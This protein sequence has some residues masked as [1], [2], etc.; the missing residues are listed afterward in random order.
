MLPV[1][2]V[3]RAAPDTIVEAAHARIIR[4]VCAWLSQASSDARHAPERIASCISIGILGQEMDRVA[5]RTLR[6]AAF[7]QYQMCK[8]IYIGCLMTARAVA[9]P[10]WHS[11]WC[12]PISACV[13]A[14]IS[15]WLVGRNAAAA[16]AVCVL[17]GCPQELL[18]FPKRSEAAQTETPQ[19]R[20]CS[21]RKCPLQASREKTLRHIAVQT[22]KM[23][24]DGVKERTGGE[25]PYQLTVKYQSDALGKAGKCTHS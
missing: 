20:Q 5:Y 3:G 21:K 18:I 19:K 2:M 11:H 8:A 6:P 25:A 9:K 7:H 22:Q 12:R 16:L 24:L 1:M 17:A 14:C 15:A 4:R 23:I 10:G 13:A